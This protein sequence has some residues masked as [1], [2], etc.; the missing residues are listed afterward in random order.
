MNASCVECTESL[1]SYVVY[2]LCSFGG[3]L[4]DLAMVGSARMAAKWLEV[5]TAAAHNV[6]LTGVEICKINSAIGPWNVF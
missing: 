2:L 4:V 6:G 5:R 1:A 3:C